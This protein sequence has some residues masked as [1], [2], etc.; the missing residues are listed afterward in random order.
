VSVLSRVIESFG[1]RVRRWSFEDASSRGAALGRLVHRLDSRRREIARRN[2]AFVFPDR[3]KHWQ[4]EVARAGFE[5]MGRTAIE[6]LWSPRLAEMDLDRVVIEDGVGRLL[7]A[8]GRGGALI[9]GSHFGNWELSGVAL[10]RLGVP[11]VSIARPLDDP[12]LDRMLMRLRTATGADVL[13]KQNAVRGALRGLRD[14]KVLCVLNDQN[15]LRNEAVFVPF[16]GRLAATSPVIAQ[17]HL[18]T[19]APIFPS[20]TVPEGSRYRVL[21]E[22]PLPTVGRDH[23]EAAR[24]ITAAITRRIEERI[25]QHPRAWLWMHD[26]WRER[27]LDETRED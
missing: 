23:P 17:L 5:Q 10:A 26:R 14:G 24:E 12:G 19:G 25:R 15:T 16:F 11:L 27:P 8:A 1:R 21:I 7:E 22:P 13:P 18:R 4:Q 9:A 6:M 20:F 3:D 2:V